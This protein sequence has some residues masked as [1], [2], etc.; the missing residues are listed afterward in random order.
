MKST[1]GPEPTSQD[2]KPRGQPR[3]LPPFIKQM[4][5]GGESWVTPRG[6]PGVWCPEMLA[7]HES[8]SIK[9]MKN[10]ES[11]NDL[12]DIPKS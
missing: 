11:S 2:A 5:G 6:K 7:Q 10:A 8:Q 3:V 1:N 4:W 12:F 9:A